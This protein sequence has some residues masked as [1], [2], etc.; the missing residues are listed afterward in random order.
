MELDHLKLFLHVVDSGTV[1]AASRL[2]H[3]TQS[4]VTRSLQLLE[5]DVGA[6]LF[7][8]QG[9]GLVLTAAGRALVPKARSVLAEVEAAARTVR[10]AALR[11][12]SDLRL[13]AVDSVASYLVPRVFGPLQVQFPELQCK[14]KTARSAALLE[15][16]DAGTLDVAVVAWSGPPRA[17]RSVR[18]APYCLQF[19][20]RRDRFAEL[21][22]V[23]QD[24]GLRQ[25]PIVEIESLPGQ[26]TLIDTDAP[27]WAVA[28]SLASV[29]ALVLAGFG[30]GAMLDF[31]LEP[32]ER[33]QLVKADI[34][35]DPHCALWAVL[36]PERRDPKAAALENALLEALRAAAGG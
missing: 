13:G 6:A 9:R 21:A 22:Q 33:A 36:G 30:I 18:I 29:K 4:S 1:N 15:Q 20:G 34:A 17:E 27:S 2:A 7:E 5:H 32:V 12:Y 31:M 19:F 24:A 8:K 10:Q 26:P 25:F 28:H 3:L 16:I 11:G 35:A 23:R 14:L